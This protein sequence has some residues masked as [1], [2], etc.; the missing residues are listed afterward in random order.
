MRLIITEEDVVDI[1]FVIVPD[2]KDGIAVYVGD[3]KASV[4]SRYS[5]ADFDW[6]KMEEHTASFKYPD[7]DDMTA[8]MEDTINATGANVEVDILKMRSAKMRIL[9]RKWTLKDDDGNEIPV[10][11]QTIGTLH[12]AI[13]NYLCDRIDDITA[14]A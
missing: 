9:L 3:D 14:N 4:E 13:S 7:F 6:E 5:S 10:N 8:I 2:K 12:P 1:K 11:Q